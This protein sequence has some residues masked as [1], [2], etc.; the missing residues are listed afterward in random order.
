VKISL[1]SSPYDLG[2]DE[3]GMALGPRRYLE[4]GADRSLADRG[5][6]VEVRTVERRG[7]FEDEPGAVS[8]VGAALARRVRDA[9]EGGAL[10]LVL[11][12]NCDTALGV[13]AGLSPSRVGVV[14][15]DAHGDFNTPETSPSGYLAGM[16]LAAATGQYAHEMWTRAGDPVPEQ[17]VVLVGVRDLDPEEHSRLES[18]DISVVGAEKVRT[19]GAEASLRGPLEGLASRAREV[20]VHLDLDSLSPEHAPGVDFPAPDGLAP[21]EV[22]EALRAVAQSF[23]VRAAAITA[24]DPER[25]EEDRTLRVGIRLMGALADAVAGRGG[26][27]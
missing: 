19:E 26:A 2:R 22:E 1:I 20:Y 10:P 7:T 16:I 15:F 5:F 21:E 25:D 12:G 18:S 13:L 6:E 17:D 11:G 9:T 3:G 14:W 8:E 4:A 27:A 23:D 24:F